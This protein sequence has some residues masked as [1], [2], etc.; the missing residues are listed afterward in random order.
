[1]REWPQVDT[2]IGLNS[3]IFVFNYG[4]SPAS[5]RAYVAEF[6][7]LDMTMDLCLDLRRATNRFR[8]GMPW[9]RDL[10]GLEPGSVIVRCAANDATAA[11]TGMGRKTTELT[12]LRARR[13]RLPGRANL[14]LAGVIFSGSIN[15]NAVRRRRFFSGCPRLDIRIWSACR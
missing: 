12:R 5:R 8:I 10:V 1:M 14:L 11:R 15:A 7:Q 3:G 9:W 6:N 2:E 4:I 13:S